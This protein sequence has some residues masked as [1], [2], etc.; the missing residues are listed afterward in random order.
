LTRPSYAA[1]SRQNDDVGSVNPSGIGVMGLKPALAVHSATLQDT[2]RVIMVV[3]STNR[4]N[5][6]SPT[7]AAFGANTAY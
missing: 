3:E 1:A 6:F 5:D 2:A 4:R 7:G